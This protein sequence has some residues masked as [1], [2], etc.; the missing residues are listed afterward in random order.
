MAQ[1]QAQRERI[2]E[3]SAEGGDIAYR[4]FTYL[5]PA[6]RSQHP[7]R[8][9]AY[10]VEPYVMAADVYSH[11]PYVGRGGW[12][13]YTGAAGWLH[14]AAIE[15]IFGLQLSARELRFRPCLPRPWQRAELSLR[16]DGRQLRFILIRADTDQALS[17]ASEPQAQVLH[18]DQP[19]D[20]T[21]LSADACFVI[22][23]R[24]EPWPSA[25]AVANAAS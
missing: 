6:H 8:G 7:L 2:A 4:Y 20:W 15:S 13:W 22:P 10:G 9:P 24:E 3:P 17:A 25:Q 5:S 1:A 23:L 14:R 12:S 16:R 11:K 18:P 21:A 19:L